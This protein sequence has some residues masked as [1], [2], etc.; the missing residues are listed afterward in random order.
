MDTIVAMKP[1]YL[2]AAFVLILLSNTGN[3]SVDIKIINNAK[4]PV[5]IKCDSDPS[6]LPETVL[7]LI[8]TPSIILSDIPQDKKLR[9]EISPNFKTKGML[10]TAA[11]VTASFSHGYQRFDALANYGAQ[12]IDP[13]YPGYF[14]DI[15][16]LL[17]YRDAQKAWDCNLV[18]FAISS[19]NWMISKTEGYRIGKVLVLDPI[20]VK[21]FSNG[22]EILIEITDSGPQVSARIPRSAT[23]PTVECS[24]DMKSDGTYLLCCKDGDNDTMVI[25]LNKEIFPIGSIHINPSSDVEVVK[26]VRYEESI[27]NNTLKLTCAAFGIATLFIVPVG[28]TMGGLILT[29]N[30]YSGAKAVVGLGKRIKW[31]DVVFKKRV[32]SGETITI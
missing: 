4:F 8:S 16:T 2:L 17:S 32:E 1:K 10:H 5:N 31:T 9:I 7:G 21:N 26:A 22:K 14:P 27:L 15:E 3:A 30:G 29:T 23:L 6:I 12:F 11:S 20:K 24:V 25:K 28:W 13:D 18:S 19:A